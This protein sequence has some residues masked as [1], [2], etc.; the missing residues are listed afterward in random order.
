MVDV[1]H[2]GNITVDFWVESMCSVCYI[3]LG[4]RFGIKYIERKLQHSVGIL[5]RLMPSIT[6]YLLKFIQLIVF[7]IAIQS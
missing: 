1:I 2:T 7:Q 5:H 4:H 3:A 6:P